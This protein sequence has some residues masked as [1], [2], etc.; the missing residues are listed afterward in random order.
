MYEFLDGNENYIASE[1]LKKS[2][3]RKIMR[4]KIAD[5]TKG[6]GTIAASFV[7][8]FTVSVN[9][10]PKLAL[11]V[12]DI[13]VIGQ[14]V[15]V[16]TLQKYEKNIGGSSAEVVTPK[17]EG[18]QNEELM[19][20]INKELGDNAEKFIEEFEKEAVSLYEEFGDKAHMGMGSDYVIR[21][22]S[23]KYLCLD[24]YFYN[25][26]GSSS[27]VHKFYTIDKAT[28]DKVSLKA[29]FKENSDYINALS[30]IIKNE[31][32]RRNNEEDGMFWVE[33]D[34]FAE[35][36][37]AIDENQS[38]FI[39]DSGNIVIVFD[40]YA[41]A[42]GAQGCPEFEIDKNDIKDILN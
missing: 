25:T 31:M 41:V 13:P 8:I 34:E 6:I 12:S 42:A 38:F 19:K 35:G 28:G 3:R 39:N 16:V 22:N 1:G 18:L 15:K 40:K 27:T 30:G 9:M 36:F 37:K 11:A 17:I 32:I 24:V 4:K 29:L 33:D 20:E 7:L 2:V 21:T 5:I 26:A 14:L 10:S 23:D